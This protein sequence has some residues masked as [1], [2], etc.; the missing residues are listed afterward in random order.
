MLYPGPRFVVLGFFAVDVEDAL[1]DRF[2]VVVLLASLEEGCVALGVG[3]VG[4]SSSSSSSD[5]SDEVD[6]SVAVLVTFENTKSHFSNPFF[7]LIT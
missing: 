1:A 7:T 3:R 6:C 4:S 5:D 2:L